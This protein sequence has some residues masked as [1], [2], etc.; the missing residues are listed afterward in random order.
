MI[1]FLDALVLVA[2]VRI[3]KEFRSSLKEKDYI[4]VCLSPL[5]FFG[6]LTTILV[7]NLTAVHHPG[8]FPS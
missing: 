5:L 7:L 8:A 2:L 6:L 3:W 1:I 4:G